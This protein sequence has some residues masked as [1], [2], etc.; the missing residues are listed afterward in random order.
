MAAQ[1]PAPPPVAEPKTTDKPAQ[2]GG[3]AAANAE[4]PKPVA[5][6]SGAASAEP[7]QAQAVPKAT[8]TPEPG[9]PAPT[10]SRPARKPRA[11]KTGKEGGSG[12][13]PE[14]S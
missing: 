10:E 12:A 1:Q 14:G 2:T 8:A 13:A 3:G 6:S 7:A 11:K 4:A 5:P 9:A